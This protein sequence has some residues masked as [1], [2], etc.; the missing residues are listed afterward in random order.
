MASNPVTTIDDFRLSCPR[1]MTES[2]ARR[3]NSLRRRGFDAIA[4]E[5]SIKRKSAPRV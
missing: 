1:S 2:S 5:V 4:V 3:Q